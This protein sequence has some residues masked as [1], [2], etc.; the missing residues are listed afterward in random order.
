ML[1]AVVYL[2]TTRDSTPT[3]FLTL[4]KEGSL[5]SHSGRFQNIG[6][7][8]LFLLPFFAGFIDGAQAKITLFYFRLFQNF[9]GGKQRKI[10]EKAEVEWEK[11]QHLERPLVWTTNSP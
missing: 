4:M 8:V 2:F 1:Q 10:K 6:V 11:T 7:R 9:R 5:Y 3:L